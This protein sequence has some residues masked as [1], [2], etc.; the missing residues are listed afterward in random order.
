MAL[1]VFMRGVNVGGH[2]SFQP[3]V[4][5]KELAEFDVVNI[6]AAGTFVVRKKISPTA[7]RD[8]FLKKLKFEAQMMICRESALTKLSSGDPF[9]G[10][11]ELKDI[12]RY[13]TVLE[14]R[15]GKLP[16][17]PIC[18]PDGDEWQVKVIGVQGPFIL[19]LNRRMGQKLVYPNEVVEKRF[20]VAAT[21][22]N[23]NTTTAINK[24]LL[25][26]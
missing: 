9:R 26:K 10:E 12:K 11:L 23:W 15:P 14:K 1:I 4:L 22:R 5:A 20:G 24:I 3:S 25:A 7:L 8:E 21:T 19:S 17:L 18:Q 6:G 16:S 13:V 2:K